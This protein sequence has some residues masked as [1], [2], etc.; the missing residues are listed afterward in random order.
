MGREERR[1]REERELLGLELL[2][3][4]KARRAMAARLADAVAHVLGAI[5]VT[6][7]VTLQDGAGDSKTGAVPFST[8]C[9]LSWGRGFHAQAQED[10][11]KI[12]RAHLEESLVAITKQRE[13]LEAAMAADEKPKS[14]EVPS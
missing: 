7:T 10:Q 11:R 1:N 6:V 12:A 13:A 8:Y 2:G 9:Y 5:G 14:E 3:A 4:Q